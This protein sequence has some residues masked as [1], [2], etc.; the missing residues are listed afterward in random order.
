[1]S[2]HLAEP[3]T[4]WPSSMRPSA[5]LPQSA[6]QPAAH[7]APSQWWPWLLHSPAQLDQA[8]A[9]EGQ[10]PAGTVAAHA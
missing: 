2:Y 6:L 9:A 5:L 8:P 10:R 3:S 4:Q 7:C 1:M